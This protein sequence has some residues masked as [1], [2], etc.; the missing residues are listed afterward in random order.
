MSTELAPALIGL[1]G[2]LERALSVHENRKV[3]R[4]RSLHRVV[5][6]TE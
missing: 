3:M 1:A 5:P 4:Q 2:D 6:Q